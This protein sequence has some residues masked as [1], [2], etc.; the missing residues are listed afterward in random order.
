MD[1]STRILNTQLALGLILGSVTTAW[2]EETIS[3]ADR[4]FFENKIRPVL[5][6]VCFI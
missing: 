6:K 2:S 3:A 1:L 4:V 5:V